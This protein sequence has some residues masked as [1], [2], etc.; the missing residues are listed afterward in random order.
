MNQFAVA[1]AKV[2]NFRFKPNKSEQYL[3]DLLNGWFPNQF[4]FNGGQLI[5]EGRIPD[6]VCIDGHKVFLELIGRQDFQKHQPE[7]LENREKLFNKFGFKTLFIYQSQLKDT[8]K[9][10]EDILFFLHYGYKE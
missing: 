5:I 6:F 1:R 2:K 9:L 4:I 7:E 10:F 3:L 8:D